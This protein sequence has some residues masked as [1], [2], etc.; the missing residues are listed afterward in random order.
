MTDLQAY[1]ENKL[2]DI[3]SAWNENDIYAISF[4]VY[5][6]EAY[7]YNGYSN[8]TKFSVSYNTEND[9]NGTGELSEERWNYAFWRQNETPII[10]DDNEN[11]GIKILF[12]W[13]RENS[14]DNVGYED[15]DVCY[16][17]EMR[18]IGKGPVGYYELLSEI[19]AVA[20]RLQD[21]GFIKNKFGAPIPIII[22]DLEYPWYIIEATKKANPNGEADMFLSAMNELGFVE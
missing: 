3:I 15:Y 9:C 4:F 16:D 6:N 12:D 5:S 11:E 14:I 1:L 10:D 22:H 18:Y 8:V 13:Y 17:D 7:E 21:S 2:R 19:T 20:K